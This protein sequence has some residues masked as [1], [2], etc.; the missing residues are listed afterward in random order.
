MLVVRTV[1]KTVI[2][3]KLSAVMIGARHGMIHLHD[4]RIDFLAYLH[5]FLLSLGICS[6][7]YFRLLQSHSYKVNVPSDEIINLFRGGECIRKA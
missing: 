3:A 4:A 1:N 6:V 7:R 2:F 5:H